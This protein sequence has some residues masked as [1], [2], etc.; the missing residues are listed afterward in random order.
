MG[1]P[2]PPQTIAVICVIAGLFLLF[3]LIAVRDA[4]Y[5][6]KQLTNELRSRFGKPGRMKHSEEQLRAA[7]C[8]SAKFHNNNFRIDD[9]TWND[10]EMDTLYADMD[11]AVSF[12]GEEVLYDMLR[13]PSFSADEL[14]RR[15]TLISYFADHAE[16]REELQRAFSQIGRAGRRSLWEHM[17][18]LES[19][20]E[21]SVVPFIAAALLS[22]ASVV[23]I[24]FHPLAGVAALV[25]MMI[26]NGI[27]HHRENRKIENS[28]KALDHIIRLIRGSEKGAGVSASE[29]DEYTGKM[30]KLSGKLSQIRRRSIALVNGSSAE[31]GVSALL[32][33]FNSFFMLD[34]ISFYS[35]LRS[36]KENKETIRELSGTA[37]LLDAS[38]AAASWRKTFSV[39][40]VPEFSAAEDLVFNG[41]YH[42]LMRDAVPNDI[43]TSR[44]ILIT[45]SNASGKSTFLKAVTI[46][47][48]LAQS[49]CTCTA[50][51][52]KLPFFRVMTS[53]AVRDDLSAGRSFYMA[54]IRSIKR[55]LEQAG[56]KAGTERLSDDPCSKKSGGYPLLC[57]LDEVLR[58][59]N[60]VERIAASS[61]ILQTLSQ[62]NVLVFA[63]THDI[64][65]TQI[66]KGSYRNMHFDEN[67]TDGSIS[68]P[69]RLLEGPSGTRNAIALLEIS[70]FENEITE[71]SR[72]A[73]E[74][75]E[76]TGGW[77]SIVS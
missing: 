67:M 75:F 68:F 26:L 2:I 4:L 40:S 48:I 63:A 8:Y 15:D 10:L 33:Y 44:S 61:S 17:E 23:L 13:T 43:D 71:A 53:M 65:L 41:L 38:I 9:I 25:F 6:K 56:E 5:R 76:Q 19:L 3:L 49:I 21:K 29:L 66:L 35:V 1:F 45:G 20:P 28:L 11:T 18:K 22:A 59:T 55:I 51:S 42:P 69:Y 12:C 50:V 73:A 46:N 7:G 57:A 77:E 36:I 64:E 30:R 16:E 31:T 27:L 34:L 54:E 62:R 32:S 14:H 39:W 24:F 72:K 58:G 60:T 47:A 74:H 37:G 52:A 70:G